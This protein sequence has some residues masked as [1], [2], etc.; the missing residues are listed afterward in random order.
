MKYRLHEITQYRNKHNLFA[1]RHEAGQILA[2]MLAPEYAGIE[3]GIV[4]AIPSGGV[5]IG[6][7]IAR[8]LVLP[9]DL[10]IVRKLQI[11]GNT[12]AGFGAMSLD[13]RRFLNEE[14][15]RYLHLSNEQVEMQAAIVREELERRN[16]LFREGRP[17]PNLTGKTVI[18]TDDGLAS[19]Y[20]MLAAADSTRRHGAARIVVAVPTALLDSIEKVGPLVD[21]VHCA[22]VID[23]WPFAVANAYRRWHDLSRREVL[24]LLEKESAPTP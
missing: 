10:L 9:H 2:E 4:L 3:N 12:E 15:L 13:G 16:C 8:R 11:P 1:D 18:L 19:G 6:I 5:P 23:Y 20:T 21:E 24:A 22:N 17:P 7:E 14:M